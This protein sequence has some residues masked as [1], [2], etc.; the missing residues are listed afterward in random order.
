M[1]P[2]TSRPADLLSLS[3]V[4]PLHA[5]LSYTLQCHKC[6]CYRTRVI[7]QTNEG[8][9]KHTEGEGAYVAAEAAAAVTAA[10]GS[11]VRVGEGRRVAAHIYTSVV[12]FTI[13]YGNAHPP[14][15][16]GENGTV[17]VSQSQW[18]HHK[19]LLGG[20]MVRESH[21]KRQPNKQTN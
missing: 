2:V 16:R 10:G 6:Q 19:K 9:A 12:L 3:S 8:N 20:Y 7:S 5:P 11:Q 21:K 14:A 1:P 13:I 18:W 15:E 17:S 4:S